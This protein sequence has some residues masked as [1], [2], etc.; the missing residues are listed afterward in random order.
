MSRA[1]DI[2]WAAG[3]ID[4]EGCLSLTKTYR[5]GERDHLR[6]P[7]VQ[8]TQVNRKP[9]DRLQELFGGKV[10]DDR[11][12]KTSSGNQIYVWEESGKALIPVLNEIIPHL[13]L[14]KQEAV[15]L[16]AF[17]SFI[18]NK[19]RGISDNEMVARN[20]VITMFDVARG[21]Q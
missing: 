9:I 14:K 6:Q 20:E 8:V 10:Y 3:F 12:R 15:C 7:R 2:A 4:G 19:G 18:G 21:R 5:A 1:T 11:A 17:C 16:L 13:V